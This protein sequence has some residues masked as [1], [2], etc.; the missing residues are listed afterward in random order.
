MNT[1]EKI[2]NILKNKNIVDTYSD[3]HEV[4]EVKLTNEKPYR[5]GTDLMTRWYSV[6]GH[7]VQIRYHE[8]TGVVTSFKVQEG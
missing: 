2:I 4:G 8:R 7:T 5:K 6:A 3:L 1:K